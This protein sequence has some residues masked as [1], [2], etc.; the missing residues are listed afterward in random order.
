MVSQHRAI[1]STVSLI[2]CLES[3]VSSLHKNVWK[4]N[5]LNRI[6]LENQMHGFPMLASTL[7]YVG[8]HSLMFLTRKPPG[9]P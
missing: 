6:N 3:G 5:E 2:C 8:C 7:L 1:H 4:N 9:G